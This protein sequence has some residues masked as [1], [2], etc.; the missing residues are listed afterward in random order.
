[1]LFRKRRFRDWGAT[2]YIMTREYA[3][4]V[5]DEYCLGDNEFNLTVKKYD[6]IPM[7]ENVIY[8]LET[9]YIVPLFVE[10]PNA[11]STLYTNDINV[12]KEEYKNIHA[13]ST[14]FVLNWWK[15]TGNKYTLN[16]LMNI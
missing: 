9:T 11:I 5:I 16:D 4:K 15:N 13:P 7:V 3:K 10:D 12:K 14:N 1:M 2:A 8:D 6:V